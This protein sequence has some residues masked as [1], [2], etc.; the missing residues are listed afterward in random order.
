MKKIISIF[1]VFALLLSLSVSAFATDTVPTLTVSSAEA[2]VGDEVTLEVTISEATFAAFGLTVTY[3]SDALELTR[4]KKGGDLGDALDLVEEDGGFASFVGSKDTGIVTVFGNAN[5]DVEGELFTLKFTVLAAG[6]HTV[7]LEI[8]SFNLA[9]QSEVEVAAV[10]GTISV[11][12][13]EEP[14]LPEG[15]LVVGANEIWL[16]LGATEASVYTFTATE[17]G[18]L[19]IAASDFLYESS[20][21]GGEYME[22]NYGQDNWVD[23]TVFTVNGEAL[24]G[25]FYGSVEV[26]AGETYTFSWSH[27]EYS[28]QGYKAT[29]NLSYSDEILPVPGVGLTLSPSHLPMN[30]VVIPAGGEVLYKIS[31]EF[32]GYILQVFGENAYIRYESYDWWTGEMSSVQIDA[33]DGVVEYSYDE[34]YATEFYIGN[35]G[36]EDISFPMDYYAPLG[37]EMNPI[38]VENLEDVNVFIPAGVY[39]YVYFRWTSDKLGTI[40]VCPEYSDVYFFNQTKE[41]SGEYDSSW[42]NYSVYVEPG[43][44]LLIGVGG[45]LY[46]DLDYYLEYTFE[47][48][49][50][51]GSEQNPIEADLIAGL[52]IGMYEKTIHYVWTPEV[53]MV[54]TLGFTCKYSWSNTLPVV[55]INGE[56]YT[57]GTEL[58]VTAGEPVIFSVSAGIDSVYGTLLATVVSSDEPGGEEPEIIAEGDV[59]VTVTETYGYFDLYDFVAPVTGTYTFFVPAGLGVWEADAFENDWFSQ[60]YVDYY[61]NTEGA[62]F[63]VELTEGEIF[64]FYVGSTTAAEFTMTYTVVATSEGGEGGEGDD[65]IE[66]NFTYGNL[67]IG[68]NNIEGSDVHW[69]F[70]ADQAGTLTLNAGFCMGEVSVTVKVNDGEAQTLAA[71]SQI[72]LEL[73]A[74]DVVKINCFTTGGYMTITAEWETEGGE[75]PVCE[76][77]FV[78]GVCIYCG[79]ED[80]NY[81]PPTEEP[82]GT[83][84]NPFIIEETP[85]TLTGSLSI[86][87]V[88]YRFVATE[89]GV[90][91]VTASEGCV[92]SIL[93]NGN[94]ASLPLTVAPGD[95]VTINPWGFGSGEFEITVSFSVAEAEPGTEGNPIAIDS[96]NMTLT[97]DDSGVYY[98]WTATEAGDIVIR[99][100]DTSWSFGYSLTINGEGL[101]GAGSEMT[102]TVAEG[103][104]IVIMIDVYPSADSE[105][106]L[107]LEQ[108]VEEEH[109]CEFVET[110]RVEATCTEDGYVVYTCACGETY[111]ETITAT[112]HNYVDGVCT[113]CGEKD[114]NYNPGTGSLNVMAIALIALMSVTAVVVTASKKEF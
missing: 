52:E 113:A 71:V 51:P 13:E 82:D 107:T 79:E 17:T 76:H 5:M 104:Q 21:T 14:E 20:W 38:V 61:Y 101:F 98:V 105:G 26:V 81:V 19:Y 83:A 93:L 65:P 99:I 37:G 34:H 22:D 23:Y 91:N 96:L 75:D 54:V 89:E 57:L 59:T 12:G 72:V 25:G 87:G 94:Y 67:T 10:A 74:G 103:D 70:T 60:P 90:I 69:M 41:E 42:S 11:E 18:T 28:Y 78:D 44:V 39:T 64:S 62:T 43:D 68:Y 108:V 63:T 97:A 86:D 30:S 40:T 53:N 7:G 114:P 77:E 46:E 50:R 55:V 84:G 27:N 2:Q 100:A 92:V 106:S 3:D 73:Q 49:Y 66:D 1:V 112:G 32:S 24:E 80:P 16:P 111:T 8:D 58:T 110:E 48:G 29:L 15:G 88:F 56:E 85:A 33:V 109:V 95:V 102:I 47:E 9:D 4:I 6:E 45:Y 35:A 31:W 36:A